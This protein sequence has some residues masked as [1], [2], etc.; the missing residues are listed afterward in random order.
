MKR[1]GGNRYIQ[2]SDVAAGR[3]RADF[4]NLFDRFKKDFSKIYPNIRL[5]EDQTL[6]LQN[7]IRIFCK[8]SNGV[9]I[10]G[11]QLETLS[12]NFPGIKIHT[13]TRGIEFDIPLAIDIDSDSDS[14]SGHS[15]VK[16][17]NNGFTE[18]ILLFVIL[19]AI[20]M[21]ANVIIG[22]SSFGS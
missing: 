8:D 9:A 21:C 11:Q 13:T 2:I 15:S 3:T 12:R 22:G 19:Y 14:D 6:D 7:Q 18:L 5:E 10:T 1:P 16:R 17:H 20:Y 4:A